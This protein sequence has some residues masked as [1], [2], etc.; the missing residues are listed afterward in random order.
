MNI[1]S[2]HPEKVVESINL[3]CVD[4]PDIT[5]EL[6]LPYEGVLSSVQLETVIY[7]CQRHEVILPNGKRAGFLTGLFAQ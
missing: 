4:L 2:P 7:A 1:G 3:S 5:Y 6:Q